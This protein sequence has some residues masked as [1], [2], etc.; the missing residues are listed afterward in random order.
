ME[1]RSKDV[2]VKP[3]HLLPHAD[4]VPT[5][6]EHHSAQ[7]CCPWAHTRIQDVGHVQDTFSASSSSWY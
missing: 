7:S 2:L 6:R 5:S 4:N 3:L 1:H